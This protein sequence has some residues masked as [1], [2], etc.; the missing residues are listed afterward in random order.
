MIDYAE[1][2]HFKIGYEPFMKKFFI[3]S[4]KNNIEIGGFDF[5]SQA[6]VFADK[7]VSV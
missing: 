4:K 2:E 5:A 3:L 6:I 1:F 7:R